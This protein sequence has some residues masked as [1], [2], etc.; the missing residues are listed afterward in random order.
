MKRG[1]LSLENVSL[2]FGQTPVIEKMS[3]DLKLGEI[4]AIVG[5][6]GSGKSTL[7]NILGGIIGWY[8]GE[9]FF[10]ANSIRDNTTSL[11]R[12]YVP[13]NLGLLP[14][15]KAKD[16][17]FLPHR[18][19]KRIRISKE[20]SSRVIETLGLSQLLHRYPSQLSGGQRQRVALAR[21]FISRPDI[22][23]MDEPFSALDTLTAET[24][25][26]LFQ[27]LWAEKRI[28]TIFAT[29]NLSEAVE[30][31]KY[32]L[33]LTDRPARVLQLIE[34]PLFGQGDEINPSKRYE[35][36]RMLTAWMHESFHSENNATA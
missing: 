25:R 4:L 16:N 29:H 27:D 17:I 23:L 15:K 18:I 33:L 36:E 11:V 13:Q 12:G 3:F 24:T 26:A 34:N 21:V 19:D 20:E 31:G 6:S 30:M 28:T 35:L 32:I 9:I 1:F 2:R 22:L 8:D 14:W 5:P 7:L 10:D